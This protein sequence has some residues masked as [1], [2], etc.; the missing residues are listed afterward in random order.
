MRRNFIFFV[1][2]LILHAVSA[3]TTQLNLKVSNPGSGCDKDLKLFRVYEIKGEDSLVWSHQDSL[4]QLSFPLDLPAG[5]YRLKARSLESGEAEQTFEI[6][7]GG[8]TIDLGTMQLGAKASELEGVTITGVPKKFIQVDAEK[9]SVTVEGNAILEVSSV[10]DAILK[11]PGIIPYPGGGFA[12][13]G[14]AAGV[15]FDGIPSP[16]SATDLENLLKSLPATSVQKI[17]LIYNPGASYD[18]N[19]SGA[20]IDIISQGRVSKWISGTITLNA[21]F[22]RNQKY[23]PSLLLSGKG[24]K[25]TWQM[26]TG[27]SSYGRDNRSSGERFYRYFDTA[28]VLNSDRREFSNDRNV[29][30]R[31]SFTYR[32]NKKSF[33]QLYGGTTVFRNDG[34]GNSGSAAPSE[35]PLLT[36]FE[37]EGRG[38]SINT[39]VKYRLFLDTL[40]RKMEIGLNY[41]RYSYNNVRLVEQRQ[42]ETTYSLL[43]SLTK[44]DYLTARNDF[45][46]PFPKWKAQLNLGLKW[47]YSGVLSEGSYRI[48]D[49]T[50]LELDDEASGFNLPFFYEEQNMAAYTELKKNFG[51]KFS[52]TAGLRAEDYSLEG[53]VEDVSL[54]NRHYFN[55]FPSVHTLYRIIPEIVFT[56]SY[57]RKIN[58]PSYSQF[59]PNVSGYYDSY[60]QST[61]NTQLKPNFV[62]RSN[63]RLAIFEYMQLSV[64]YSLS[65][66]INLGE[67][68]ADSNSYVINQT[69]RTYENVQS[70]SY[71]FSLPLPFGLFTKGLKFFQE[72]IDVDAVSFMYLYA[73]NN[74]T[75]I[76]GYDYVNGNRSQWTFGTYSQI[77]LPWKI[78]LNVDYNFTAKGMFQLSE[79]TR[80]IHELELVLSREFSDDKWRVALTVQD[81]F[82]SNASYGQTSYNPLLITS[83]YKQ[84][85]RSVWIKISRS[86]G[87]YERPSVKESGIPAGNSNE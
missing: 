1:F 83:Y 86:F 64:D 2:L 87:R 29:Y 16:L 21:G 37:R 74:K 8:G 55:L 17:D 79:N 35:T 38:K 36:F 51:K 50:E 77:I 18:A 68:T 60:T 19:Y 49:T 41:Y 7:T 62:H 52:V 54:I 85:T 66:S 70:F 4:C 14:Q 53:K 25:Y 73:N 13:G 58:L 65:N 57:S 10:Y 82:N 9:T 48:N 59:D 34:D 5:K 28:A 24:K 42:D 44:S 11:I 45:E 76:P 12:M 23:A 20:I 80:P 63:A 81:V 33:L 72:A 69:F 43:K 56:A 15:Y 27:Y 31:P 67:V 6:K 71:F 61:G 75:L 32:F 46:L 22:N 47:S 3:Q 40:N 78:R 39:G 30:F 84:D 26:Q